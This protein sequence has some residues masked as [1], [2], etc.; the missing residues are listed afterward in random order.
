[1][2]GKPPRAGPRLCRSR[3][4]LHGCMAWARRYNTKTFCRRSGLWRDALQPGPPP[5]GRVSNPFCR[6]MHASVPAALCG[7]A[8]PACKPPA[9]HIPAPVLSLFRY[10]RAWSPPVL[11]RLPCTAASSTTDG[12]RPDTVT[13]RA[14]LP[15]WWTPPLSAVRARL[16]LRL[17]RRLQG[18]AP[19]PRFRS[20]VRLTRR[21][22]RSV[23]AVLR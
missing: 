22:R 5:R 11:C 2:A 4:A 10:Q 7:R 19:Q 23:V 16:L 9:T 12:C 8:A 18:A 6:A 14:P 17:V 1:V 15:R 21:M 20:A 3:A 13:V